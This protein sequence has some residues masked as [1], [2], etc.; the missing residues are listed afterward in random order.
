MNLGLQPCD[1]DFVEVVEKHM[2]KM[3]DWKVGEDTEVHKIKERVWNMKG[4][5]DNTK[6]QV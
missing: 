5:K 2:A 6:G 3:A 1:G 4:D